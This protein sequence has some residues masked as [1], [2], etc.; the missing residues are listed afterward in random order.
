MVDESMIS[1]YSKEC[2]QNLEGRTS[3]KEK[4]YVASFYPRRNYV[5]HSA[6]LKLY[7][8]LGM[9]LVKVHSVITFYQEAYAAP[10]IQK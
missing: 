4:K 8:E 6:N 7:L 2:L 10:Y 9:K 1:D 3:M 5:V